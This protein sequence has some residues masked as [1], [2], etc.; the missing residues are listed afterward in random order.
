MPE[1]QSTL[2][3]LEVDFLE[4]I[5][6]REAVYGLTHNFY[7]YPARFSHLFARTAIELFTEVG[8]LVFDPFMGGG[9]TLVEAHY[10]RR[11]SVGTDI[12]SLATLI[13]RVK[14]TPLSSDDI[15]C[16]ENWFSEL[17][18]KLTLRNVPVRVTE[19][20]GRGYQR[21]I[22][23]KRT[24]PLRK[25]LELALAQITDLGNVHHQDFARCVLL[26]TGQWALHRRSK[27]P[28]AKQFRSQLLEH[29]KEM[30]E[31]MAAF[32]SHLEET[33]SKLKDRID[34]RPICLNKSVTGI[35]A[36]SLFSSLP[37]PRLILTSP[38]Y[39]GVHVLYHRWQ[40]E[41]RKETLAPFWIAN[42]LDGAG[43]SFYTL[44][45]RFQSGLKD[46][47]SRAE[48]AFS[49]ISRVA[50]RDTIVVQLVGF[51]DRSW[52][53]SGY[54]TMMQKAGFQE[55]S[56]P[57]FANSADGRLWRFVPNRKWYTYRPGTAESS[58]EVVLFHQ[59][60]SD[61]SRA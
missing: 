18:R 61:S 34:Y 17:P 41:G 22:S 49:S 27:L 44:G 10:L 11:R 37:S 7:H 8:E 46:Y 3:K 35:E 45:S 59:L 38:P 25:T 40:V 54:L 15:K 14:T 24:W 13:S 48:A 33:D 51:S 39:P 47:F 42:T 2:S 21:N 6:S 32:T 55:I 53:L 16:I 23:G 56:F 19:W 31:S 29:A 4:A 36:D 5:H 58:R 20:I 12:N 26:K 60:S 57:D 50:N 1:K 28:T 52:Q 43:A 9:T 30:L